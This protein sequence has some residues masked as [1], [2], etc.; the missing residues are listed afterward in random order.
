M[1]R[2]LARKVLQRSAAAYVLRQRFDLVPAIL[3]GK[4][5]GARRS[6]SQHGE[7][8]YLVRALA[9]VIHNGYYVDVGSN[10]PTQISN[11]YRLYCMGMRGICVE[12]TASLARMHA[13]FRGEDFVLN[14]AVGAEDR[15]MVL[16]EMYPHVFSTFSR[17][18]Y[19]QNVQRGMKLLREVPVPMFR[20]S[21]I[22]SSYTPK[23]R[24]VFALLS[25]DTEGYD[26]VVLRSND[27]GRFRPR[28][29]VAEG[30]DEQS[31]S[32][33]RTFLE[34]VG[35]SVVQSFCINSIYQDSNRAASPAGA[36]GA[37][38]AHT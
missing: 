6:W 9:D 25:V 26:E 27:W 22:L 15:L 33:I 8:N 12:P 5:G 20:L 28:L 32:A 17:E 36:S 16:Y 2:S 24:N 14:G 4:A 34:S 1:I 19:E 35:Y 23:G 38:G 11:T 18:Q 21:T 37:V 30:N 7:D 10:H 31:T 29:V 13:R 3:A